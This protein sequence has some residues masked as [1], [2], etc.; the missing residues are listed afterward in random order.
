MMRMLLTAMKS[1][2]KYN[3]VFILIFIMF[4]ENSDQEEYEEPDD[5][6]Y[7]NLSQEE[8]LKTASRGNSMVGTSKVDY[9]PNARMSKASPTRSYKRLRNPRESSISM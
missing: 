5:I 2:S 1:H 9:S 6:S 4:R 8:E 3:K 7:A